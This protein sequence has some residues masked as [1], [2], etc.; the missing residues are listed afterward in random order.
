VR[1]K[2]GTGSEGVSRQEGHQTLKAERSGQ[3]EAREQWTSEPWCAEGSESPREV[4]AGSGRRAR[5]RWAT[6]WRKAKLEERVHRLLNVTG[7]TR[8]RKTTQPRKRLTAKW[9]RE[10]NKRGTSQGLEL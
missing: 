4:L 5:W 2:T 7:A 6:L 8:R 1:N 9:D 10:T 3:G